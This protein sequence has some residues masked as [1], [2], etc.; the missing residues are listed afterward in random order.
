M[1]LFHAEDVL[2]PP[3][4]SPALTSWLLDVIEGEGAALVALNFVFCSD[5]YLLD[6]NRQYLQ[7]DY[8]TDV[9]TFDYSE[10]RHQVF[11]DVFVSTDR[12]ADNARTHATDP[13]T[14]LYRVLVH[15]LL[16]LLGYDDKQP[17]YR[18]EMRAREDFYLTKKK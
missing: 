6:M 1:I 2:L 11:G 9:I 18:V 4:V 13:V 12:V 16:H 14:E 7:H 8:Y 17:A 3:E 10:S 5:Q 15:G